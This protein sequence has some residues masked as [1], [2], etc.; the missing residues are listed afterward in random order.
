MEPE[1]W[2]QVEALCQAALER[3]GSER[4]VFLQKA[5]GGD[6]SLRREVEALLAHETEAQGFMEA[7]ALQVIVKALAEDENDSHSQSA[8]N[9]SLIGKTVSHYR[10]LEKLGGGGMGL[11]YKAQDTKLPRLVALKFLPGGLAQDPQALERFKREAHAASALNHP[12]ICVIHDV[13][14]FEEQPFIVMEYLEGQTLKHFI[15]GKPLKTEMLLDLAIQITDGLEA[16]D[17]KGIIH[18][19]IKPANIFV[20]THG[21]AKILDFGLAKLTV[22]AGRPPAGAGQRGSGQTSEAP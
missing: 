20:T 11:V 15:E 21:Q 6:Q 19:D 12:N 7:P 18:R 5:C 17:Q 9:H 22:R 3:A 8:M 1:R 10:I 4:A 14:K 13:D 16:A 2:K